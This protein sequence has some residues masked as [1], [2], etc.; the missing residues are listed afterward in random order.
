MF[1]AI[2]DLSTST[3]RVCGAYVIGNHLNSDLWLD[4]E[5][6]VTRKK[7]SQ[8]G[9]DATE[10]FVDTHNGGAFT[11][12]LLYGDLP[13]ISITQSQPYLEL[14]DNDIILNVIK[15]RLVDMFILTYWYPLESYELAVVQFLW[16]G[17]QV[18]PVNDL[19]LFPLSF[20]R[21][22][23]ISNREVHAYDQLTHWRFGVLSPGEINDCSGKIKFSLPSAGINNEYDIAEQLLKQRVAA[24][25]GDQPVQE[26]Q[27]QPFLNEGAGGVGDI[28]A[29]SV[30]D[31]GDA[32]LSGGQAAEQGESDEGEN[33]AMQVDSE[34]LFSSRKYYNPDWER[35]WNAHQRD[36]IPVTYI[37]K[38]KETQSFIEAV[39][40]PAN[41]NIYSI[42]CWWCKWFYDLLLLPSKLKPALGKNDGILYSG[43]NARSILRSAL[44][45]HKRK[46]PG[47]LFIG[48]VI[49]SYP[50]V[51]TREEL[52]DILKAKRDELL[53]ATEHQ[54]YSS[55]KETQIGVGNIQHGGMVELQTMNG[56][57]MGQFMYSQKSS[58]HMRLLMGK[59]QHRKKIAFWKQSGVPI[60]IMFDESVYIKQS[61][62][63]QILVQFVE[64]NLPVVLH[65]K[66]VKITEGSGQG[67][68]NALMKEW[69]KDGLVDFFRENLR[70][71]SVDGASKN[72]G[73]NKGVTTK[74]NNWCKHKLVITHCSA[75]RQNLASRWGLKELEH[76]RDL[77]LLVNT[78]HNFY[79]AKGGHKRKDHLY[80]TAID[81]AMYLYEPSYIH[82]IRWVPSE[83]LALD[84]M[85]KNYVII[86]N[87]LNIIINDDSSTFTRDV[88]DAAAK[89]LYQITSRNFVAMLAFALDI[90][91]FLSMWS[92]ELQKTNGLLFDKSRL[93]EDIL[94][95]LNIMITHQGKELDKLLKDSLC[96]GTVTYDDAGN[97]YERSEEY[98]RGKGCSE[99]QFYR[100]EHVTWQGIL[101]L[102]AGVEQPDTFGY[103]PKIMD[104]RHSTLTNLQEY[105]RIYFPHDELMDSLSAFDPFV[106]PPR[107]D[108]LSLKG[109]HKLTFGK[110][111]KI[112]IR[113]GR[114]AGVHSEYEPSEVKLEWRDFLMHFTTIPR[115]TYLKHRQLP[116]NLFWEIYLGKE[117]VVKPKLR[118]LLHD[119]LTLAVGTA[120][121]ERSFNILAQTQTKNRNQMGVENINAEV[122]LKLNGP[123][124]LKD[125]PVKEFAEEH[126]ASGK[127]R[128]DDP[129]WPKKKRDKRWKTDTRTPTQM[130]GR[131]SLFS[132]S[133]SRTEL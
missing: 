66:M 31:I 94:T 95:K 70:G 18:R 90:L 11:I 22:P 72:I 47:H 121:V 68:F 131:S 83:Y 8:E 100:A 89:L 125:L 25:P 34:P 81:L 104:V 43:P 71:V 128:A 97:T 3:T 115:N 57:E 5:R 14:L 84:R 30:Y 85:K 103:F 120:S 58:T 87:N 112:A 38:D 88:R 60:S 91:S 17:W 16:P 61:C 82:Q 42:I 6:V 86:V 105:I 118:I 101:L 133:N 127:V 46:S 126:V 2:V 124:L 20:N 7:L 33:V 130:T 111:E 39:Y 37:A 113:L 32:I 49:Q 76:F 59:N 23:G 64:N 119:S 10:N 19:K 122:E 29:D 109:Y 73:Y 48:Q 15:S 50:E 107:N 54:F 1:Q 108:Y 45:H 123:L 28:I 69:E 67:L 98:A 52:R 40:D 102:P 93:T 132:K 56:A 53:V 26:V 24:A 114:D 21:C 116:A 80:A 4:D 63:L 106:L 36:T 92:K 99:L 51:T 78:V 9:L 96:W 41:P 110:I 77:E 35:H 79:K 65:Y 117:G 55:Y 44:K 62:Y 13:G 75:H 74:L 12:L 129:I 27:G